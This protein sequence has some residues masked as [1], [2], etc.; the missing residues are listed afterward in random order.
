MFISKFCM[1][2][3]I[4]FQYIEKYRYKTRWLGSTIQSCFENEPL[5]IRM[6]IFIIL[7]AT[8][9]IFVASTVAQCCC[10]PNCEGLS[11]G[12][13]ACAMVCPW[14]WN[15]NYPNSKKW[16]HDYFCKRLPNENI[17]MDYQVQLKMCQLKLF[18]IKCCGI[19]YILHWHGFLFIS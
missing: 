14:Q 12:G 19:P 6:K 5:L 3:E 11:S 9:A 17:S 15:R 18:S 7:A 2:D 1:W 16:F 13:K 4:R 10:D 8:L